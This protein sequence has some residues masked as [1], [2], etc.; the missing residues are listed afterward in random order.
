MNK[1]KMTRFATA[2]GTVLL[3]SATW[4]AGPGSGAGPA[5]NADTPATS[6]PGPGTGMGTGPGG[7]MGAGMGTGMQARQ[8]LNVGAKNT[9]GWGLMTQ[10]ERLEHRQ[11]LQNMHSL[12]ECKAYV[13]THHEQM[14]ARAKERGQTLPAMPRRDPCQG[15]K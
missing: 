3:A 5:A 10:P 2:L 1:T 15:L 6:T 13:A 9:A 8:R 12:E 11:R 14:A 4:A 7:G